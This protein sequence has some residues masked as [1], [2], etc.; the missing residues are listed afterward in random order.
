MKNDLVDMHERRA[1]D[2]LDE[3]N[4]G[5]IRKLILLI[6]IGNY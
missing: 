1:Y 4:V 5:I 2:V 6:S 3:Y